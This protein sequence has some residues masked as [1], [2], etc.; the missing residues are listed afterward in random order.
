MSCLTSTSASVRRG[1]LICDRSGTSWVPDDHHH[2][3]AKVIVAVHWDPTRKGQYANSLGDPG[4]LIA[5]TKGANR[6]K[7]AK[8]PEDWHPPDEGCWCQYAKD[9]TE[10]KLEWGL[11]MTQAEAEAVIDML[12]TCEEPVEVVAERAEAMAGTETSGQ[13]TA[14]E[15]TATPTHVSEPESQGISTACA[16]C[17]EAEETRVQGSAG[18]GRGFLKDMVP[19]ARDG[20]GYGSKLTLGSQ[21][22]V[23][24]IP[25]SPAS[26]CDGVGRIHL[27]SIRHPDEAVRV[28]EIPEQHHRIVVLSDWCVLSWH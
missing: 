16:S 19:S 28:A 6:S 3:P 26:G 23:R 24:A 13:A 12:D 14:E 15:A 10:V 7:G 4:H 2:R 17:E 25:D 5:V 18:G 22:C 21:N 11:T 9:W 27:N 8:G 1:G 20:Y